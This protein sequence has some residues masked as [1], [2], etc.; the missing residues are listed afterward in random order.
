MCHHYE[1]STVYRT[2]MTEVVLDIKT[3]FNFEKGN[4]HDNYLKNL[5]A[6]NIILLK[7]FT[8]KEKKLF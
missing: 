2:K 3:I 7:T 5:L 6:L 1:G 8:L 4:M